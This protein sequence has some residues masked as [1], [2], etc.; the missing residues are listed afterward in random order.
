[1]KTLADEILAV[2]PRALND[3]P[4]GATVL[5]LA[6]VLSAPPVHVRAALRALH[7]QG[8]ALYFRYS[9]GRLMHAVPQGHDLGSLRVCE[10]CSVAFAPDNG[11]SGRF[12]TK[13]CRS[14]WVWRQPKHAERLIAA[15]AAAKSTPA[16]KARQT[17]QNNERWA[18]PEA[19]LRVA[20]QSRKR[21][22][23]P[24]MR[25]KIATRIQAVNGSP[26]Q[27]KK[28]AE[29]RRALWADPDYRERSTKAIGKARRSPEA[30]AEMSE[31]AKRR[32]ADPDLRPKYMAAVRLN[33]E[34][35]AE[36][37]RG[38]RQSPEHV[39]KR[40]AATARAKA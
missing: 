26:E 22:A 21:W 8:R 39:A 35:A 18:D 28:A 13:S 1:M 38:R 3:D 34:K 12:C 9:T 30:R 40:V 33:S 31:E 24:A 2:L 25:A 5:Q 10:N 7:E 20:E 37:A 14:A 17:A 32:W 23:D 15:I 11:R 16:A 6:R 27:R 4:R 29:I 36:A 19:R